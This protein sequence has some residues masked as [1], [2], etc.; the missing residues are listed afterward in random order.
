[1]KSEVAGSTPAWRSKVESSMNRLYIIVR[2]DLPPGLQMAQ[3][4][5]AALAWAESHRCAPENVVVLHISSA[6]MLEQLHEQVR[7]FR[8]VPFFE[9]DLDSEIT[10]VAVGEDA[11]RFLSTLPLAL[12]SLPTRASVEQI[13]SSQTSPSV[14]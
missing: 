1:M 13:P 10:A 12:R 8:A 3:A 4:C 11:R 9:P 6:S 5:H 7:K 14:A 2:S